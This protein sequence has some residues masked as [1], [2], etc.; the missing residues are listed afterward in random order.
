[1]VSVLLEHFGILVAQPHPISV[2]RVV[3]VVLVLGGVVMIRAF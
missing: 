3:G 1:M 2:L